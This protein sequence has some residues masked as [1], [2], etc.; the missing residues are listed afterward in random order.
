MQGGGG[1]SE[2]TASLTPAAGRSASPPREAPAY[3]NGKERLVKPDD[4]GLEPA[5]AATNTN[6]SPPTGDSV[7]SSAGTGLNT[8]GRAGTEQALQSGAGNGIFSNGNFLS[9]GDGSYTALQAEG[10]TY[11]IIRDAD[12][13]YPEEARSIG[14]SRVV[15]VQAKILVGLDGFV[16]SVE[17]VNSVPNLGFKESAVQALR[18]MQFA[19]IY[20]QNHNVKMYFTKRI[21]FQP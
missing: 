19:P 5:L 21:Y 4:D 6:H 2:N 12:A 20:Y 17:I 10:I 18:K 16:E 1:R 3:E 9:N 11:T 7:S 8:A 14:Y 15:S 13:R